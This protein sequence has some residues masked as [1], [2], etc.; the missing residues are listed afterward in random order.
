MAVVPVCNRCSMPH[1]NFVS[2]EKAKTQ[3]PLKR[4]FNQPLSE[5]MWSTPEGF[6]PSTG[7]GSDGWGPEAA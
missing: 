7:W 6:K 1:F 2:C 5:V 3:Q 4:E